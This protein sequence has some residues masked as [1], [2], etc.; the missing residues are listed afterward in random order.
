MSTAGDRSSTTVSRLSIATFRRTTLMPYATA[1]AADDG[2]TRRCR[3]GT[4]SNSHQQFVSVLR[5]TATLPLAACVSRAHA[6]VTSPRRCCCCRRDVNYARQ[7]DRRFFRAWSFHTV[8]GQTDRRTDDRPLHTF[9]LLNTASGIT[10]IT[11]RVRDISE[12]KRCR[13]L[14]V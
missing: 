10:E 8:T 14:N 3:L 13:I 1:A 6:G 11:L 9:C 12:I 7:T 5:Q 4:C 2:V